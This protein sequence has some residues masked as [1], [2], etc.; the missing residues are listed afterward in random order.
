MFVDHFKAVA[1]LQGKYF[2]KENPMFYT[3]VHVAIYDCVLSYCNKHHT[4]NNGWSSY[5]YLVNYSYRTINDK[6]KVLNDE[7]KIKRAFYFN[8]ELGFNYE[9]YTRKLHTMY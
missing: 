7:R 5:R 4:N 2:D 3:L 9:E 6:N 1:R 8:E